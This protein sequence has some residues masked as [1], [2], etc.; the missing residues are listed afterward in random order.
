M[1]Y[2]YVEPSSVTPFSKPSREK[3]LH[4]VLVILARHLDQGLP[5]NDDASHI[6]TSP[7]LIERVRNIVMNRVNLSSPQEYSDTQNELDY[8][9]QQW[10]EWATDVLHYD[11]TRT[12]QISS[13]LHRDLD[14]PAYATGWRTMDSMRSVDFETRIII[15]GAIP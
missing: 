3:A 1:L 10:Q 4:A 8:R 11:A 14:A 15:E 12:R 5:K 2:V 9:F 13:L 6:K 7:D